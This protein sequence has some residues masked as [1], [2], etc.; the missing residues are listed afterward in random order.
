MT[1][2]VSEP[3]LA[4]GSGAVGGER[5]KEA[6]ETEISQ[7]Y[8]VTN[9]NTAS[10]HVTQCSSL[11]GRQVTV[12]IRCPSNKAAWTLQLRHLPRHKSGQ[13]AAQT[14]TAN[15]GRPMAMEDQGSR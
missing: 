12:L 13:T 3:G 8:Q 5:Q 6:R 1:A 15:P 9:E 14:G 2:S 7:A 11:I 4:G 10:G